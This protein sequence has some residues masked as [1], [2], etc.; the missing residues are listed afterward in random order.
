MTQMRYMGLG[1]GNLTE[2]RGACMKIVV[3]TIWIDYKI[4]HIFNLLT[5]R[6]GFF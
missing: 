2:E 6:V 5:F 3:L 1:Q 4:S